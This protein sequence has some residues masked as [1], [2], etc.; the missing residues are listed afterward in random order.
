MICRNCPYGE[1]KEIDTDVGP[2]I[3][4]ECTI[5]EQEHDLSYECFFPET[6]MEKGV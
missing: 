4:I 6:M 2:I 1:I 3:Y 5:D